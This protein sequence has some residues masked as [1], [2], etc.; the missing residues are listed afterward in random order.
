M[1]KE[2]EINAGKRREEDKG[3]NGV[4]ERKKEGED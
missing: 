2:L 3:T 4:K 1:W